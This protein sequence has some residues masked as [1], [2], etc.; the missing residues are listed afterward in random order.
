MSGLDPRRTVGEMVAER[1]ARSRVFEEFRI[2]YCCGGRRPLEDACRDAGIEAGRVLEALDAVEADTGGD[3][4]RNWAAEGSAALVEHI[5]SVH[6][7][8]L[9][10]E[11]PRLDALVEKVFRVH[12]GNHPELAEVR[13]VYAA[14]RDE[15]RLHMAKEETILFPAILDPGSASPRMSL[16]APIR[17]ME[18]EHVSAGRALESLRRLTADY[19]PPADACNTYRAM[20]DGL[21]ALERDLHRHIHEENNVLFPRFAVRPAAPQSAA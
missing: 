9:R 17:V 13:S 8:Y 4:E 14:L 20:L 16:D 19:T 18:H 5:L 2:D 1:P 21:A 11:L 6:H 10:R 15:L 7:E 3:G 12:G